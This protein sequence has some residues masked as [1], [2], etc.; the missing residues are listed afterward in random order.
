MTGRIWMAAALALATVAGG[1]GAQDRAELAAEGKALMQAF[2]GKLKSELLAAI[3]EGGPPNAIE[4]C[5]IR[6]PEIAEE[7]SAG[8]GWE[9]A[10]SSHL[11][12]NPDNAPDTYTAEAIE[13]FLEAEAA[14]T[15]ADDLV[16]AEIVEEDGDRAFRM[17]RAIPTAKLCL[18]C[19]GGP[20]VSPE[21]EA[22]LAELYPEDEA[23]GF[24]VGDMRGVFTLKKPL[25]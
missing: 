15:P 3:E 14:G 13:A 22:K 11:L 1:A 19:H 24:D 25:D 20:E 17:V 5:N 9:V 10:R 8:S 12:R 4:V 23:R 6:A 16:R 18:A 7:V 2:G 21:T